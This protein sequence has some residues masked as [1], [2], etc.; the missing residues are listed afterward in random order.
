MTNLKWAGGGRG[1]RKRRRKTKNAI[2]HSMP[3]VCNQLEVR[4]G[5]TISHTEHGSQYLQRLRVGRP[6]DDVIQARV[7]LLKAKCLAVRMGHSEW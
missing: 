3:K 6:Q 2:K 5:L 7:L 1:R 4:K